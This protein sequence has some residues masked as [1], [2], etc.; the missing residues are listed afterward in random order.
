LEALQSD[1]HGLIKM[2]KNTL[3]SPKFI[4][5]DVREKLLVRKLQL[6][7]KLCAQQVDSSQ[8]TTF[9]EI[10]DQM[11]HLC[12][13]ISAIIYKLRPPGDKS[14]SVDIQCSDSVIYRYFRQHQQQLTYSPKRPISKAVVAFF[15]LCLQLAKH[16]IIKNS[17]VY[18]DTELKEINHPHERWFLT[19]SFDFIRHLE[20]LGIMVIPITQPLRERYLHKTG[21]LRRSIVLSNQ[22]VTM[23]MLSQENL[24]F[25][26]ASTLNGKKSYVNILKNITYTILFENNLPSEVESL[27]GEFEE[28]HPEFFKPQKASQIVLE[29]HSFDSCLEPTAIEITVDHL[30]HHLYPDL[31]VN[32]ELPSQGLSQRTFTIENNMTLFGAKTSSETE[33]NYLFQHVRVD[34]KKA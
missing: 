11:N 30:A 26:D 7:N 8:V 15:N 32:E 9:Y 14:S 19:W 23:T 12:L 6:D 17:L 16:S 29:S 5:D 3:S 18:I 10:I 21:S 4:I 22:S 28:L 34:K 20:W 1:L 13:I 33:V 24:P 27:W 25:I 2:L 31:T